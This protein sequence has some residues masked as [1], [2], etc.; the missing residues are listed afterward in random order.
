MVTQFQRNMIVRALSDNNHTLRRLLTEQAK[1]QEYYEQQ[2]GIQRNQLNASQSSQASEELIDQNSEDIRV[3]ASRDTQL[4]EEIV[5]S[6][7]QH[8]FTEQAIEQQKEILQQA[9]ELPPEVNTGTATLPPIQEEMEEQKDGDS[10]GMRSAA[11]SFDSMAAPHPEKAEDR[12]AIEEAA[13]ELN[14]QVNYLVDKLGTHRINPD[15][16]YQFLAPLSWELRKYLVYTFKTGKNMQNVTKSFQ[17]FVEVTIKSREI[18]VREAR[19]NFRVHV[20]A[21]PANTVTDTLLLSYLDEHPDKTDKPGPMELGKNK[22]LETNTKMRENYQEAWIQLCQSDNKRAQRE[23]CATCR[24]TKYPFQ[25]NEWVVICRKGTL[26]RA[27]Q[28]TLPPPDGKKRQCI[29]RTSIFRSSILL[30]IGSNTVTKMALL[31]SFNA[32]RQKCICKLQMEQFIRDWTIPERMSIS[33]VCTMASPTKKWTSLWSEILGMRNQ[34]KSQSRSKY[35]RIYLTMN[36]Q[37]IGLDEMENGQLIW[38][39]LLP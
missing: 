29:L 26:K 13:R 7:A 11:E 30:L 6:K 37:I 34:T 25:P 21:V 10:A 19:E 17:G 3:P 38:M 20:S 23:L 5:A 31:P 18:A 36:A 24:M 16:V 22:W 35:R 27:Y 1:S 28:Y 4:M 2:L 15:T 33:L 32:L 9:Q 8:E 12:E 39:Q 14:S